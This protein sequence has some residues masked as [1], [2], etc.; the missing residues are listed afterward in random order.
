MCITR[1]QT[2]QTHALFQRVSSLLYFLSHA[3]FPDLVNS[4]LIPEGSITLAHHTTNG[5]FP[6]VIQ[7]EHVLFRIVGLEH[8]MYLYIKLHIRI[9]PQKIRQKGT[10]VHFIYVIVLYMCFDVHAGTDRLA[11]RLLHPRSLFVFLFFIGKK[12][13]GLSCNAVSG[14]HFCTQLRQKWSREE[15]EY[16]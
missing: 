12:S 6:V 16:S 11:L 2:L 9:F 7:T 5:S 14:G 15:K 13:Q 1:Q 3:L 10:M 8:V 4:E